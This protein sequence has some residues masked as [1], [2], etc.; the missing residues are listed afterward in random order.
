MKKYEFVKGDMDINT[1][2]E[3]CKVNKVNPLSEEVMKDFK[4][5]WK[6]T[7]QKKTVKLKELLNDYLDMEFNVE[8]VNIE[9]LKKD[10]D[11]LFEVIKIALSDEDVRILLAKRKTET[12]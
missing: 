5:L 8:N 3:F 4:T 2:L 11:N 1:Y 10:L 7:N 9:Q 12:K 6:E